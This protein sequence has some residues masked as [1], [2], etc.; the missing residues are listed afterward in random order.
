MFSLNMKYFVCAVSWGYLKAL[1]F[2]SPSNFKSW[3]SQ[4]ILT[5]HIGL[6]KKGDGLSNEKQCRKVDFVWFKCR[7]WWSKTFWRFIGSIIYVVTFPVIF[8]IVC[9]FV[10]MAST[11]EQYKYSIRIIILY[12]ISS[13]FTCLMNVQNSFGLVSRVSPK[14]WLVKHWVYMSA[15]VLANLDVLTQFAPQALWQR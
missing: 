6:W 15:R 7:E 8:Q 3:F 13:E 14:L 12:Y 10:S 9:E 1:P 4:N 11:I 2:S 5:W